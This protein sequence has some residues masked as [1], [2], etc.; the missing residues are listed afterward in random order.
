MRIT[1][2]GLGQMGSHVARLLLERGYE[3]TVWNRSR[4]AAETLEKAG[5]IAAATPA[6]AVADADLVFTMVHDDSALA[7]I[8]F[9][10]GALAAIRKGATHVSLSTVSP[11][12]ADRLDQEHARHGQNFVACPVFG[13]PNIAAEGKL[14]LAIAGKDEV[15]TPLL[16]IFETF[17]RGYT[18]VGEKPSAALAVK[19]G[20]NFLITAMIASLSEGMVFAEA[21]RIAPAVF[22]E[23]VNSALFQSPFYASYGKVMLDPPAEPAATVSLGA[24][25][26]RLFREAAQSTDTPTPLADRFQQQ[27]EAAS[28]SGLADADWAA[29]YY[30]FTQQ[31]AKGAPAK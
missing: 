12:L 10:Q 22:L 24:K 9:E 5:A 19:V 3:L 6:L 29:G 21:H 31:Q 28:R 18:L 8:L 16:P 25:D 14:W 13:R 20:G 11:A 1:C 17:S 4:K 26:T 27:F 2:L 30:Q 23:T 15:V 7:S